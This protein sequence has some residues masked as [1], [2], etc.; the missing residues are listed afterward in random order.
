MMPEMT[1]PGPTSVLFSRPPS[2]RASMVFSHCT[3]EGSCL[4]SVARMASAS[5]CG[6]TSTLEITGILG[7]E[8]GVSARPALSASAAGAMKS[9]WNAPATA[10]FTTMRALNSGLAISATLSTAE[11][12][13]E[14]A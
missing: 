1:I 12:E 8:M 9:V 11:T 5:V 3:G 4:A 6:S 7:V 13:P 2:S 14:T 10:S